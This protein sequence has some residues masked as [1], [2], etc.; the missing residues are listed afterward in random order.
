MSHMRFNFLAAERSRSH[1]VIYTIR[2]KFFFTT[3]VTKDSSAAK[4]V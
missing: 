2:R 3:K 1:L 4:K